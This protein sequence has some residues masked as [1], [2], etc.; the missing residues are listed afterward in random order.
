MQYVKIE[1]FQW[2]SFAAESPEW[3]H[4]FYQVVKDFKAIPAV[5]ELRGL[6]SVV[7]TAC[8]VCDVKAKSYPYSSDGPDFLQP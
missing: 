7:V 1:C 5:E 6:R 8:E 4:K 2:V 3:V